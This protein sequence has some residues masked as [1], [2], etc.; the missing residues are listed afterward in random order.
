MKKVLYLTNI[1]VPYRVRFFN[2]LAKHCDL[3]VLY[4]RER[5]ANRNQAW[6]GSVLRN[7][8]VKHLNG[9]KIGNEN[10]FSLSIFKEIFGKLAPLYGRLEEILKK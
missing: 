3:T 4:E 2:E 5:S 10:T 6:A 7:F 1:E 8:R 9:W